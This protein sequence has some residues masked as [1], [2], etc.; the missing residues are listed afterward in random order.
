MKAKSLGEAFGSHPRALR[1]AEKNSILTHFLENPP[2]RRR[3]QF[4][5]PQGLESRQKLRQDK[6]HLAQGWFPWPT[7]K[8]PVAPILKVEFSTSRGSAAIFPEGPPRRQR[9]RRVLRTKSR[10][11]KTW[12]SSVIL[13]QR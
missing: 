8:T 7:P 2:G 11:C 6:D 5:S 12:G 1:T 13:C 9:G 4:G 3:K 10:S